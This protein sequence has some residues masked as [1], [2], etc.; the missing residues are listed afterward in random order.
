MTSSA[1]VTRARSAAVVGA[2]IG[3]LAAAVALRRSG[4]SVL[5]HERAASLEALGAGL[6]LAP[7]AVHALD[8]LGLGDAV[9]ERGVALTASALLRPDGA[10]L[11][12]LDARRVAAR[13][14]APV[15]GVG[16]A[17]LHALL[18]QALGPD[19]V[20]CGWPVR[21]VGSLLP[22]HDLV[23]AADGMR[24]AARAAV[25]PAAVTP[26]YAG[27]TA[28]RAVVRTPA[29]VTEASET[30]GRRERFGVVPVG[31]GLVYVFATAT[32][33]RAGAHP[34]APP[35]WPSCGGASG[36]GTRRS[37]PCSTRSTRR[38]CSGTTCT[39]CR[40]SPPRCTAAPPC[41]WVTP[42]TRSSR[43][44]ARV[45]ASRWRTRSCW[46]TCSPAGHRSSPHSPGTPRPGGR[47]PRGSTPPRGGWAA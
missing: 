40:R 17:A 5:V 18:A 42:R 4:W 35:S 28:W 30:W 44:S 31:D 19:A 15:L 12:R 11:A 32:V 3:G 38:P 36:T 21:D 43:T 16:R 9:R 41:W 29:A 27:Y 8:A 26:A 1:P 13:H 14:G 24:S 37:R 23:V 47:G 39:R 46:R 34:T 45:P 25:A 20:R 22:Q 7:N 33:P 10:P 2:G 6:V